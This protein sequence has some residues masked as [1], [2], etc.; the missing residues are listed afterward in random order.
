L[1]GLSDNGDPAKGA[2]AVLQPVQGKLGVSFVLDVPTEP[3]GMALTSDE[4]VV[5]VAG[6][7]ASSPM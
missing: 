6:S 3:V 5:A 4:S 2:I 7:H 1:C